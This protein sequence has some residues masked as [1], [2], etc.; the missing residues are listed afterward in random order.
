MNGSSFLRDS[1]VCGAYGT[2]ENVGVGKFRCKCDKEHT[3]N[4]CH[5]S[6]CVCKEMYVKVVCRRSH[7]FL[8][9]D[10]KIDSDVK[11]ISLVRN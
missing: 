3:G 6:K 8:C 10:V 9:S 5:L 2:C 7:L 11:M 1:G 4:H